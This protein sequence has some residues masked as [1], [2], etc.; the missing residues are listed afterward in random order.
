M[1][2]HPAKLLVSGFA[3]VAL[4]GCGGS[5]GVTPT[6]QAPDTLSPASHSPAPTAVSSEQTPSAGLEGRIVYG[7]DAAYF[8]ANADW[9]DPQRIVEPDLYC[10]LMRISPDR[11]RIL[12]MPGDDATGAVRGGTL[13]IDG[14]SLFTLLPASD[15]TLN[16]IPQAWSPDG[17]RIAF[18][19]WDDADASRTG[20]YTAR[21]S[22]GSDLVRVTAE[23]AG[24]SLD[25]PLDY[26]P[27]GKQLVFFRS[28]RPDAPPDFN[29]DLGGSL[30]IV[31]VDGS[32][33]RELPTGQAKPW[34]HARWSPDGSKI[35]FGVERLQDRGGLWTIRPDGSD[36]TEV[37]ADPEGGFAAWPIWS[38][39]GAKLMFN[40]LT[41]N[42]AFEHPDS[43]VHVVNADGSNDMVVA[44][45]PGF[46]SGAG[47]W[48]R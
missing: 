38:P 25:I 44:E 17:T 5:A 4:A 47:D 29:S 24:F 46:K 7:G 6:G 35:V 1:R 37:F 23:H 12:T 34:W 8:V 36:L 28:V 31:N 30:W 45:G 14:T 13:T 21:A 33:A 41:T 18:A 48:W 32:G 16:L 26:S 10:C 40:L 19:A 20:A 27:D 2:Q 42:D 9:T 15:P 3:L 43:S 39:D 22:D 11:T